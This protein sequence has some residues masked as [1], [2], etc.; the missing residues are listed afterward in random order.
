MRWTP[1][2]VLGLIAGMMFA[3]SA[4]ALCIYHG[5]MNAKTTVGQEFADSQWVV[6]VKLIAAEDHWSDEEDSWTAYHLQVM[7]AFQGQASGPH[8]H[9][10][11][12]RQRRFLPR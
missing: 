12:S 1:T 4:Q 11:L 8:R 3:S 9:V 5:Q 2:T 6:R 10:H 7:A